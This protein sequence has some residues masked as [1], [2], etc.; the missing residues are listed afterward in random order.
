MIAIVVVTYNRRDMLSDLIATLRKQTY[1]DNRIVVV[2]NGSTDGTT[3]W[4]A[5]QPDLTVINQSNVGGAGGFFT[6]MKYAAENGFDFCWVMDDDVL[7]PPDALQSLV[8]AFSARP[9][10]GFIC[11][12]VVD[13]QGETVN[14]PCPDMRPGPNG[15]YA[16]TFD[17]VI[18]HA[19]VKVSACTFVSVLVPV[20]K[21]CA[22]GLPF[23]QFF[24]WGDDTEY[25]YR[26]SSSA[27]CFLACRS[28]VTHRRVVKGGLDIRME[29][30]PA[31][32]K[33][34][35][36]LVRNSYIYRKRYEGTQA[37]F[38]ARV[39]DVK[40][41]IGFALRFDFLRLGVVWRGLW[42]SF[43]FNPKLEFPAANEA[44]AKTGDR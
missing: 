20:A 42:A 12:R 39:Q 35:F 16:N 27:P 15:S 5:S 8:D 9:D 22:V 33:N 32:I 40:S 29:T 24:I 21:I 43:W 23:R 28:V 38:W 37:V 41:I 1:A 31:R 26:L 3:E 17:L 13:P 7:C 11:S 14:T 18:S 6:G 10:A 4:L 44:G 19:M 25:T 30:S 36:Y 2:N 34:Y